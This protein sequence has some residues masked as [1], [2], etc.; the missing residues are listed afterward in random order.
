MIPLLPDA[1]HK[2][3]NYGTKIEQKEEALNV[4]RRITA[5]TISTHM[6]QNQEYG[7]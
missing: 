4:Y 6:H 1:H 5:N 2:P 3:P 7:I